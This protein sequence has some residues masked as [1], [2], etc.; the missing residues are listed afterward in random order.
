VDAV[1]SE[2]DA[3]SSDESWVSAGMVTSKNSGGSAPFG[4]AVYFPMGDKLHYKVRITQNALVVE[5]MDG[6]TRR[7]MVSGN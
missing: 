7:R 1:L 6:P 4:S 2:S 5:P 3:A